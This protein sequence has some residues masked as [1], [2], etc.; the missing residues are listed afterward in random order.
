MGKKLIIR[1]A[2]F[3]ENGIVEP[4]F[5]LFTNNAEILNSSSVA[6][7]GVSEVL[8]PFLVGDYEKLA[9]RTINFISGRFTTNTIVIGK[10]AGIPSA[11]TVV[12][13]IVTINLS[14]DEKRTPI[15]KKF[16]DITLG[17]NEY[18]VVSGAFEAKNDASMGRGLWS[19]VGNS[20][21]REWPNI[22]IYC[23]FGYTNTELTD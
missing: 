18:L 11:S 16:E 7:T 12:T 9:G 3:S 1:G 15:T 2:D 17:N 21:F 6:I 19:K 10:F 23:D 5:K 14:E 8:S 22:A 13:P 20:D 4:I